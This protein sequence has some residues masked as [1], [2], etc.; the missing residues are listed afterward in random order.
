MLI[1]AASVKQFD[2]PDAIAVGFNHQQHNRYQSPITGGWRDGDDIQ[3]I[4]VQ[5]IESAQHEIL[6]P[7]KSCRLQRLQT[8]SSQPGVGG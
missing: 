1:G 3:Q 5:A 7:C 6:A 8:H 4:L 2:V